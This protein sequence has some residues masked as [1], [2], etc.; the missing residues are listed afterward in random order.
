MNQPIFAWL[1]RSFPYLQDGQNVCVM[2]GVV[3]PL[4]QI[5]ELF[6]LEIKGFDGLVINVNQAELRQDQS[7]QQICF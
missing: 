4:P 7:A 3:S 1:F 2:C 6:N 5:E